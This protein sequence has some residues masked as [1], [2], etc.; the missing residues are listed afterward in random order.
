M[1]D[2]SIFAAKSRI[3]EPST[4]SKITSSSS[5]SKRVPV[6]PGAKVSVKGR[7]PPAAAPASSDKPPTKSDGYIRKDNKAQNAL[8]HEVSYLTSS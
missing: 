7:V 8:K 5:T 4:S 2:P 1:A 6:A 3:Y